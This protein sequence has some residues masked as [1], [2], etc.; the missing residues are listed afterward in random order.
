VTICL[1][2]KYVNNTEWNIGT[3]FIQR[4]ATISASE[5]EMDN[6]IEQIIPSR[7]IVSSSLLAQKM[8]NTAF[9]I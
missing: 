5:S 1:F 8:K 9:L 3:T 7:G 6:I 2:Y 4:I